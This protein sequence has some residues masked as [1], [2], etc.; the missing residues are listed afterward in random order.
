MPSITPTDWSSGVLGVFASQTR[1]S[2]AVVQH[3]VREGPAD[4]DAEPVGHAIL[5]DDG[6]RVLQSVLPV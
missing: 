6:R 3:D 1:C 4:V 5:R 2:L